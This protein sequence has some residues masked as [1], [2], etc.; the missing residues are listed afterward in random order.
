MEEYFSFFFLTTKVNFFVR[1][2]ILEVAE[3]RSLSFRK[4]SDQAESKLWGP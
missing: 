3:T 2:L 1:S 4:F